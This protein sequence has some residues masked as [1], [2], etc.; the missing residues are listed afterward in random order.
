MILPSEKLFIRLVPVI[1]KIVGYIFII[2]GIAALI[3]LVPI[4][5]LGQAE[6]PHKIFFASIGM[7]FILVSI[8]VGVFI[9]KYAQGYFEKI[10]VK[11]KDVFK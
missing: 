1:T 2:D 3:I 11:F 8:L 10:H 4:I 7:I 5:F 6:T 9:L